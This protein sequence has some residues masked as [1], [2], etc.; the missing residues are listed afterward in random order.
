MAEPVITFGRILSIALPQTQIFEDEGESGT[1]SNQSQQIISRSYS[2]NEV[3]SSG[4]FNAEIERRQPNRELPPT[5]TRSLRNTE[6]EDEHSSSSGSL[7]FVTSIGTFYFKLKKL[8]L[9]I[10]DAFKFI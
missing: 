3:I 8:A 9:K 6:N 7:S 4:R 2:S 10:V 1:M 5:L